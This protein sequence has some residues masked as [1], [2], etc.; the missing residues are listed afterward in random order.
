M[1]M[2]NFNNIIKQKNEEV[3]VRTFINLIRKNVQTL[4]VQIYI[5]ELPAAKQI[6]DMETDSLFFDGAFLCSPGNYN[7]TVGNIPKKVTWQSSGVSY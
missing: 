7:K 4:S 2:F 5:K 3:S 6:E 1:Q